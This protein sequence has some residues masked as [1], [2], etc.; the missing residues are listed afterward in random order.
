MRV[1]GDL[2]NAAKAVGSVASRSAAQ[3]LN[4]WA[5][6]GRELEASPGTSRRD[7]QRVLAGRAPY[8]G[9]GERGQALVR[10]DWDEQVAVR[11]DQLNLAAEF[12]ES[13]RTW[14]DSDEHGAA[15]ERG[16]TVERGGAADA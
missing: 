14:T 5:R 13:G 1:D 16:H 6:I 7:I 11:R 3:Q 4:H 15:V 10:A 12:A 9:L 8:D 2:F